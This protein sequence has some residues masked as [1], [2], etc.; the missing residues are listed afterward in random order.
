MRHAI[1][2][3]STA[4]SNLSQHQIEA[5]LSLS[6]E[7]ND[8]VN[9][10]GLLL[11]SEGNFFQIMEGDKE[12]VLRVYEKISQDRRHHGIIQIVGRD[13]ENDFCEGYKVG[14]LGDKEKSG[15]DVPS[16]YYDAL[17]CIPPHVKKPMLKMLETFIATQ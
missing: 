11:Y 15:Y 8:P 10:K 7:R 2:Y 17:Q 13:I 14:I 3:V 1:C 12:V 16:E 6:K 5:L 9:I 4:N